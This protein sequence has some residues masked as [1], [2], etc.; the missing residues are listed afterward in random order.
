LKDHRKPERALPDSGAWAI[1]K[2]EKPAGG[3]PLLQSTHSVVSLFLG[4]MCSKGAMSNGFHL[5]VAVFLILNIFAGLIRVW[6]GPGPW[7]RILAVQLFGTEGVAIL[8]LL[9]HALAEPA[10]RDA[11][12]AFALLATLAMIALAREGTLRVAERELKK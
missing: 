9:A 10:L 3:T 12:L 2:V 5:V 7:D 6:R 11:G 4:R 1:R 8:L